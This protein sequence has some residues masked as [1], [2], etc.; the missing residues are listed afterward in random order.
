MKREN[1]LYNLFMYETDNKEDF[2]E[3]LEDI[4]GLPKN[5]TIA[6]DIYNA[7][8]QLAMELE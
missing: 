3:K 4:Y 7:L 1:L 6:E 5:S 2:T 8:H